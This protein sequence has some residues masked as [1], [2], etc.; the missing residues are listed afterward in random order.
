MLRE[1]LRALE[2]SLMQGV[3]DKVP[4]KSEHALMRLL[5]ENPRLTRVELAEKAGM[6]E[7]DIKKSLPT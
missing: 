2:V 5:E 4:D 1:I 7:N 6:S 3:P